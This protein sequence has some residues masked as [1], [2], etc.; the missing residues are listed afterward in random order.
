MINILS[1][2]NAEKEIVVCNSPNLKE[3]T[4]IHTIK[5]DEEYK[6]VSD[7][8]YNIDIN[9]NVVN[10]LFKPNDKVIGDGLFGF[11]EEI[12]TEPVTCKISND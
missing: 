11:I 6:I 4:S 7:P 10:I 2:V 1:T 8:Y 3:E 9:K 12:K 5:I